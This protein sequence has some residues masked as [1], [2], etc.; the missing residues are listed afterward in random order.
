[1]RAEALVA[2]PKQVGVP[3]APQF[4]FGKSLYISTAVFIE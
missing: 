2:N 3:Q 1:M 4:V